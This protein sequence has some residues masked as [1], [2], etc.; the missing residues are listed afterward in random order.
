ML[1]K[2]LKLENIRSYLNQEINFQEGSVLLSGN[3]GS[4]KSSI[5]LAI[6]FALFGLIKG[7]ISGG[8]LLRKG[9][10]KGSVELCFDI[11]DNEII[12]KRTL[13]KSSSGI[14]QDAGYII[15]N[16]RKKDAT[17]V[18]LKQ[19][20]LELLN[21]P[22][23]LLNK[24]SLIYR[25]TV[26]TPQEEMKNILLGD[27]EYRLDTLR[28]V[29]N[30]DKY[31]RI[32]ENA[33]IVIAKLKEKK[34]EYEI[35][36]SGIEAKK[37]ELKNKES[38]L[39]KN[40]ILMEDIN[41]KLKIIKDLAISKK[42]EINSIEEETNKFREFKREFEIC[43]INL[44]NKQEKLKFN[45]KRI[46]ELD[47]EI[48]EIKS[49]FSVKT[50]DVSSIISKKEIFL[51]S[52][53]TELKDNYKKLNRLKISKENSEKIMH[54]IIELDECQTCMQ[55]VSNE[56]KKNVV[57]REEGKI[58]EIN[59][60]LELLLKRERESDEAIES[61][62]KEMQL[63]RKKESESGIIKMKQSELE[64]K[65][66]LKLK[67]NEEEIIIRKEVDDLEIKNIKLNKI[68]NEF[69]L[70]EEKIIKFRQELDEIIR[71]ERDLD[72][73]FATMNNEIRNSEAVISILKKEIETSLQFVEKLKKVRSLK[74]NIEDNFI[75]LMETI[76][77]SIMLKVHHDFDSLFRKWFEMLVDSELI[78]VRLDNEFSPLIEQN[79]YDIDYEHLSGG[80]KTAAALAY[81]LA[82]N[83]VIN[84]LVEGIKTKDL[85][86]LDEPTDGFSSEQLDRMKNVLDELN[87]KQIIIVSHEDKIESFV[88]KVIRF[89]KKEHV[90]Y[91]K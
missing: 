30:I 13:K 50:E 85:I 39:N 24:K 70:D 21:Y 62:K 40:K 76:E 59:K 77:K 8:S 54:G 47:D 66:K 91:V 36:A 20:I 61:V 2:K 16:G 22:Q 89:E 34:N 6:E 28:R 60:E 41:S 7:E 72:I 9:S 4:G 82:L 48:N 32:R 27:L 55:K 14:A 57:A 79:G 73:K 90:S 18:E 42:K 88:E 71:K 63:L 23:E 83:Q 31:K 37:E 45:S 19:N 74:E 35:R 87:M 53:E 80:E 68:I 17:A 46:K 78:K 56:Y 12:I 86:I 38:D 29:F 5:L 25:Y 49:K 52:L 33:K 65:N 64:L 44:G 58:W 81:R 26:Y 51:N 67:L 11:N 10:E 69:K 75:K 3:I 15:I 1:I 84:N 43:E